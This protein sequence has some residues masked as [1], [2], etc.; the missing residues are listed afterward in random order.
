M[1][2]VHFHKVRPLT[3]VMETQLPEAMNLFACFGL[4]HL[5]PLELWFIKTNQNSL[6]LNLIL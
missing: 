1:V 6:S 4:P 3:G 2:A 5:P